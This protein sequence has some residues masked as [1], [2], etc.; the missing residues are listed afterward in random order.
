[1][2]GLAMDSEAQCGL[3]LH[4]GFGPICMKT[5]GDLVSVADSAYHGNVI[6]HYDENM[7]ANVMSLAFCGSGREVQDFHNQVPHRLVEIAD[8]VFRNHNKMQIYVVQDALPR[9]RAV[10]D[11]S[12]TKNLRT[13]DSTFPDVL[14]VERRVYLHPGSEPASIQ[15]TYVGGLPNVSWQGG[16]PNG[17]WERHPF[18]QSE[19]GASNLNTQ[20]PL[21]SLVFNARGIEEQRPK[22]AT[23]Y[24]VLKGSTN[25]YRAVGQAIPGDR[26]VKLYADHEL[27][28]WKN[29]HIMIVLN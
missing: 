10:Q 28:V 12:F 3:W 22:P 23:I 2:T 4:P 16:T 18:P 20:E 7:K 1:M 6:V 14:V 9:Y 24:A 26:G 8:G 21:L 27:I 19:W 17:H 15:L 25:V 5:V 11:L 13:G 29:W